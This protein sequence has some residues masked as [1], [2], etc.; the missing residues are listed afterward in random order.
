MEDKGDGRETSEGDTITMTGEV[1]K[2]NDEGTGSAS[3]LRR[4]GDRHSTE[5]ASISISNSIGHPATDTNVR[6]GGFFGKCLA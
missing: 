4:S 5:T 6:E 2:M 3:R 1:T